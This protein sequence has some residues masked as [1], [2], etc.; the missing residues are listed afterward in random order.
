LVSQDP[1][2]ARRWARPQVTFQARLEGHKDFSLDA[3]LVKLEPKACTRLQVTCAPSTA[4]PREARLI[5]APYR[6]PGAPGAQR[7]EW[8]CRTAC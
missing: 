3:A 8:L 2:T 1:L 5:V 7:L 6:D 4:L